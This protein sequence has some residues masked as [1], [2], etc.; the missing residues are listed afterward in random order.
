M[1][2]RPPDANQNF[3]NIRFCLACLGI[4]FPKSADSWSLS[5]LIEHGT[6]NFDIELIPANLPAG[7]AE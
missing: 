4:S 7:I 5:Q 3:R 1:F 2:A 6:R